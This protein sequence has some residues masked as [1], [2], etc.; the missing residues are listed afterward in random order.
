MMTRLFT[1]LLLSSLLITPFS[2]TLHAQ[3]ATP[4]K[5]SWGRE[6][7]PPA[8]TIKVL[9]AHDQECV[10]LEVIGKYKIMDP[11]ENKFIS[12]RYT[13][14]NKSIQALRNGLKWGEEFPGV[15]QIALLPASPATKIFVNGILYTGS[16]A[17]YDIGGTISVVN[18]LPIEDYLSDLLPLKYSQDLSEEATAALVISERTNAYFQ[19]Q[20]PKSS[21]WTVDGQA[22]GYKGYIPA[23]PQSSIQRALDVT[24]YMVMSQA[25]SYPGIVTPFPLSWESTSKKNPVGKAKPIVSLIAIND[26]EKMAKKGDHA[27]IILDKAFPRSSIHLIPF[28]EN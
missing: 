25:G 4:L 24:R 2:G 18:D 3:I 20:N 19:A 17:I 9:I 6:A 12:M 1:N 13:G 15:H 23:D 5:V 16:I 14:K 10:N 27:A 28:A 22:I 11:H 21:Y 8:P 26:I 7:A